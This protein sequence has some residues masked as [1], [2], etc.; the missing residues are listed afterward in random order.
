MNR[1]GEMVLAVVAQRADK[2]K[3]SANWEMMFHCLSQMLKQIL[4][5]FFSCLNKVAYT[6]GVCRVKI[7][8]FLFYNCLHI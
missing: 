8:L 1:V 4:Y 5:Y 6:E 2:S 7:V 3:Q